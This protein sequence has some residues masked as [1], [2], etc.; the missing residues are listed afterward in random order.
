M[1]ALNPFDIEDFRSPGEQNGKLRATFKIKDQEKSIECWKYF[2]ANNSLYDGAITAAI[3]LKKPEH[4]FVK[5]ADLENE[6]Y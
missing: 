5:Y 1:E 4:V 6:K 3:F 2:A